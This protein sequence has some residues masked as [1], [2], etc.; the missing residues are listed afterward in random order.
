MQLSKRE[1]QIMDV[2][3]RLGA[4]SS[5]QIQQGIPDAPGSSSVRTLVARLE[6]KGFLKHKEEGRRFVY[7]PIVPRSKARRN[8]LTHL[9]RTFFNGSVAET[10]SALIDT[11]HGRI[12]D[13]EI[14]RMRDM[15]E[16][17]RRRRSP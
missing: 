4:A 2:V 8:A 15:I 9:V 17:A 1:R 7:V 12:P 13:D 3:Y 14:E 6:A 11:N 5:S 10:L 16:R